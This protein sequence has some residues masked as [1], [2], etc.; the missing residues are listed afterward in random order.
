M[1]GWDAV[2]EGLKQWKKYILP[3]LLA[4]FI[5]AFI[6]S[7]NDTMNLLGSVFGWLWYILSRF[8]IGFAIA[9]MVNFLVEFLKK[10]LRFPKWLALGSSYAL[11]LGVVVWMVL[12]IAPL[13]VESVNQII[14]VLTDAYGRFS[15]YLADSEALIDPQIYE[16]L[17]GTLAG[18]KEGLITFFKGLLNYSVIE[19]V[20]KTSTRVLI[21]ISFGF[22][23]SI[24]A[25]IDKDAI[26][27][28][29]KA[30][31]RALFPKRAARVFE[32]AGEANSTFSRFLIGKTL[33]SLIIGILSYILYAIFRLPIAPFLALVAGITNMIP[34]FGPIVG[35]V[36]TV[37]L[38]FCYQPIYALY[39]LIIVVALQTVDGM[40]L[41]P[42]ILGD[43]VGISPLLTVVAISIGG[44]VAGF[45][46]MFIGVP[47]LAVFKKMIYHTF[48]EKRTSGKEDEAL[49]NP[50]GTP[51]A[52]GG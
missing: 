33:D 37:L 6:T 1:E 41:G 18:I 14:N 20:L 12:Y 45:L 51:D 29:A 26:L 34:Y 46:G 44:D 19:S 5:F 15:V 40:L 3:F 42:K 50:E 47:L 27:R 9:Y 10:R 11:L 17:T 39:G 23:I 38:L 48:I 32:L 2:F 49:K 8:V 31:T 35:G 22:L 36:I 13:T 16:A 21:N 43:A 4:V 25:I 30:I 52:P 24:Y 28:N 7:Y